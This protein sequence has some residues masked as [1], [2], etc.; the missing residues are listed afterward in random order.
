MLTAAATMS[1]R[2]LPTPTVL[3]AAQGYIL[4]SFHRFTTL[5][6]ES[7][8]FIP[9]TLLEALSA[10][11][12]TTSILRGAAGIPTMGTCLAFGLAEKGRV[13]RH[14][15]RIISAHGVCCS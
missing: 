15:R 8:A 10:T 1:S 11:A 14:G 2:Q 6:F 12:F 3:R 7:R 13:H 5:T 4:L 9:T